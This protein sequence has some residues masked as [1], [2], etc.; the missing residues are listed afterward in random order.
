MHEPKY[1]LFFLLLVTIAVTFGICCIVS[2]IDAK[3]R[4]AIVFAILAVTTFLYFLH[5]LAN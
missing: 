5:R 1:V 2:L 3:W 4:A